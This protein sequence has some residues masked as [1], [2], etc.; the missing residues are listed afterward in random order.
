MNDVI[1]RQLAHLIPYQPLWEAMQTF[2]ARRQSQTTDEIWFLEHEPVFT[3]GL[4]G[5]PEHV[6]NSGNIP[7]IR[8]D[9][10][11]QVT[12]HGP[13]QLMMYLLL[14]LNRLGLSTRTFVRTIENTVAE[15]LQEW[16]IPAQG[17]ETAPG[18][19]VDDKK[20]CSIG[21]RVRKGFSYH[22]LALNVAMDLTPF[23]CIN[24]CGFKGLMMTQ[25]QDYV[26][27]IEMDAVKRTIIPLF[28]K[29][30]G[31]N[32]PAIMVETSL[33]FLIDDHLRSFSEKFGER[34]TVTN[35]R[36]N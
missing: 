1:I 34:E 32:Q 30:F 15:S 7:L 4:A 18:V 16:G 11:G 29:N 33:E 17:K 14:D 25:I 27:P 10:G 23:S 9:R 35:S 5:K 26:N 2:T 6:L 31:Y 19:Y 13:G 36:Q 21:L 20:I 12:Y 3:Q 24:P 8:T 22:G 28:L